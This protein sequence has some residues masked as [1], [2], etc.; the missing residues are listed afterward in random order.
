M[1]EST[2][3]SSHSGFDIVWDPVPPYNSQHT[4]IAELKTW[5]LIKPLV[6]VLSEN[7]LPKYLWGELLQGIKH[8]MTRTWRSKINMTPDEAFYGKKPDVS[9]L[10]ALG[11]NRGI[12]SLRKSVSTN[13]P[14]I[15]LR[16]A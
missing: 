14:L 16:F 8:S 10:R 9:G 2:T 11:A 7:Q 13:C 12:T 5:Y 6:T 1:P 3:K 4:S 15:W